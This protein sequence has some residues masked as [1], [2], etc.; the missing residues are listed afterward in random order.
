MTASIKE[1]SDKI[2]ATWEGIL[3]DRELF[4]A[5]LIIIVGALSFGLGRM[6]V[7]PAEPPVAAAT[8]AVSEAPP[9]VER[10]V[11]SKNSD[12]YHLP[13]CSGA[14][15]ISPENQVWFDSRE[16]AEAAGYSPAGNCEGL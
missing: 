14:Q 15:R 3:K 8:V 4:P 5:L 6:S 1:I 10:Y 11:G 9:E 7:L 2:K 12:K 13:W 16:A